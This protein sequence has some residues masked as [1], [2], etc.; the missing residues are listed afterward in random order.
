M[1]HSQSRSTTVRLAVIV[2]CFLATFAYLQRASQAEDVPPRKSVARLPMSLD[3]WVG[4]RE[5]DFTKQILAVLGVDD[6][7]IRTYQRANQPPVGLYVGYHAG[8]R[9]G[10]TIHSPLNCLPGA[11]WQPIE[12]GRTTLH[13]A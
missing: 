12:Q 13:V 3:K 2:A 10:D 1:P 8:Q 9:Q 7:T 11:G 6:Y 5:P 4:R